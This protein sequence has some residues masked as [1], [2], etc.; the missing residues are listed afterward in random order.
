MH[1]LLLA[2]ALNWNADVAH[3]KTEL[4]KQHP[5]LPAAVMRE[6][7][8][9][10]TRAATME[11]HE[12]VVDLARVLALAEDGHTRLTF[13]VEG[14]FQGHSKTAPANVPSFHT[15]PVRFTLFDDGLTIT[16]AADAKL[17]GARVTR[18][19]SMS[20]EEAIAAVMPVV[21]GDNDS[22]KR[23]I[24]ASY[25]TMPEVLHARRVIP[26]L[27][28]AA[29][30]LESGETIVL[31]PQSLGPLPAVRPWAFRKTGDAVIFDYVEVANTPEKTLAQFAD[32][33]FRELNGEMAGKLIIDLRENWGGNGSL[34]RALLHHILRA[35]SLQTPGNL[36]VLT[37]R[38][39]FSAAIMFLIDLEQH[40]N[41]IVI[42]EPTGGRPNHYGDSRR[43]V[44]PHSGLTVRAS[45]LYWQLSD[46]RDLRHWIAPH[47][48]APPT[49]A[50]FRA[51]RDAAMEIALDYFGGAPSAKVEGSWS[52]VVTLEHQRVP[53]TLRDGKFTCE[54]L[55]DVKDM[56]LEL[57][58]GT[59]RLAGILRTGGMEF[60]VTG[61]RNAGVPAAG[62]QAS[63]GR[64]DAARPAGETPAFQKER[65]SAP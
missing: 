6:L 11:T 59:K 2:L 21:H 56:T 5:N 3:L 22:Q 32:E 12:A 40:T 63:R 25:L 46:P 36:F 48:A 19:G 30:T 28:E 42:G 43:I 49:A 52:G 60:L 41:A 54:E 65:E 33:L 64:R 53:F 50:D 44:L 38:R 9:F 58:A 29:I 55:K 8:S 61:S 35:K 23:E 39:T 1:A 34:N 15:L 26:S 24:A 18:I 7:D 17:V 10:R 16:R 20:A 37:G 45:T 51:N 31:K 47:V 14:F 62:P 57:R 27:D 4:S 13:P